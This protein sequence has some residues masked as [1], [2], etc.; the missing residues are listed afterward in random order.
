MKNEEIISSSFVCCGQHAVCEKELLMK[1]AAEPIDYFDD[2]ELDRFKGRRADSYTEAE[3]EE[4]R[5]VLYTMQTNE[6]EDW[7]KS[8]SLR[9]IALPI[10]LKDEACQLING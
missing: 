3:E 2:E 4:F 10:L 5:E 1:A 8:L 6:I 7:L 9:G